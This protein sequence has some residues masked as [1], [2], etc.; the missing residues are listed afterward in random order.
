[1]ADSDR[2]KAAVDQDLT[3]IAMVLATVIT[4]DVE[5]P[6]IEV[7]TKYNN[8]QINAITKDNNAIRTGM[9]LKTAAVSPTNTSI[10]HREMTH[11]LQIKSDCYTN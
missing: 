3:A 7:T 11:F 4:A 1:M 2:V 5:T 6:T 10:D 8:A 9:H